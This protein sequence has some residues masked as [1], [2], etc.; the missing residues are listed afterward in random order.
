MWQ[1]YLLG[2]WLKLENCDG[3]LSH[4]D[5]AS[6]KSGSWTKWGKN[7]LFSEVTKRKC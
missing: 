7:H 2:A 1:P 3:N 4:Q 6:T 5:I